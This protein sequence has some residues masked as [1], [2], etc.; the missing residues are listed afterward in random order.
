MS[1]EI[2]LFLLLEALQMVAYKGYHVIYTVALGFYGLLND[3]AEEF[4]D[5]LTGLFTDLLATVDT[6]AY[7][8]KQ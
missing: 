1:L 4:I 3:L 8:C 2:C 5:L 7:Q 6:T